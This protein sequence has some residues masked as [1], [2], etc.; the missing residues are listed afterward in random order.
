L[1]ESSV[2]SRPQTRSMEK[3]HEGLGH[4]TL[5]TATV[6]PLENKTKLGSGLRFVRF[7]PKLGW[8]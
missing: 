7:V 2:V 1:V 4:G 3:S 5:E 6:R 8:A